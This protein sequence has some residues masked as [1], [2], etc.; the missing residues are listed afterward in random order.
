MP[1]FGSKACKKKNLQSL[2]WLRNLKNKSYPIW[3]LDTLFSNTK[4]NNLQIINNG[5]WHFTNI[6]SPENLF[7]KMSNFGH[8]DEFEKS[9]LT[10]I[11]LKK[12]IDDEVVFYNHLADQTNANKWETEYKLKKIDPS[13]LPEYLATN[14]D[15]YN[16]WFK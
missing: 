16:K 10:L 3:R 6:M 11:D 7:I 9:G 15:K 8:H 5:G 12:K 1:W 4:Y 14:K 13:L 2:S